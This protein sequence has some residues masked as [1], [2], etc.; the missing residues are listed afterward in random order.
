ME[1]TSLACYSALKNFSGKVG[2][3]PVVLRERHVRTTYITIMIITS[4][5]VWGIVMGR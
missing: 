4:G 1:E 5:T 2:E 3:T